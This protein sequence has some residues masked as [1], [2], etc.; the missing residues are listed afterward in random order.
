MQLGVGFLPAS[1]ALVSVVLWLEFPVAQVSRVSTGLPGILWGQLGTAVE[2]LR[3]TARDQFPGI[4][5][6]EFCGGND[7]HA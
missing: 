4:W 7:L 5:R 6:G 2:R 1:T 3:L